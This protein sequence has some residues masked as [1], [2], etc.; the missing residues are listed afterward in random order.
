MR[1]RILLFGSLMLAAMPAYAETFDDVDNDHRYYDAIE[2]V[3]DEGI[4]QGYDNDDYQPERNIN[5]AEFLK[6]VMESIDADMGGSNCFSDVSSQW[7]AQYACAAKNRGIVQGYTDGSFRPGN[8]ITYAEAAALISRAYGANV[9]MNGSTMWYTPYMNQ[10]QEWNAVPPTMSN[11]HMSITRGEMAYIIWKI[12]TDG[13]SNGASGEDMETFFNYDDDDIEELEEIAEDEDFPDD[14]LDRDDLFAWDTVLMGIVKRRAYSPTL[15]SRAYAALA[16]AQHDVI[17][18]GN[19]VGASSMDAI[20]QVSIDVLCYYFP[21]DCGDLKIDYQSDDYSRAVSKMVSDEL[22]ERLNQDRTD[23]VLTAPT[24][25]CFFIGTNPVGSYT[26]YWDYLAADTDDI[27]VP[28][29]PECGSQED[30]DEIEQV[31]DSLGD[32]TAQHLADAY[33]WDYSENVT[34]LF[35]KVAHEYLDDENASVERAAT[36]RMVLFTAVAD[37]FTAAWKAKYT[38]WTARPEQRDPT[39]DPVLPTPNFP[40]YP[41]GH[42]SLSGSSY[43]VLKYFYPS[44]EH[45]LHEMAITNRDAREWSGVHFRVDDIEGMELGEDVGES[46]I[47]WYEDNI[48]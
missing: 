42:S 11:M 47:E 36:V 45:D 12:E 30:I 18:L 46:V 29:P 27:E 26:L 32:L 21:Q 37:G 25:P 40:A 31:K 35:A 2:F 48:D 9:N 41:S 16:I 7:Y 34:L 6:I 33:A 17:A 39:I 43:A 10:L 4:V 28:A 5:R 1:A 23:I 22:I 24:G 20:D 3:A 13:S 19:E 15:N 38:F 44:K 14:N 8:S